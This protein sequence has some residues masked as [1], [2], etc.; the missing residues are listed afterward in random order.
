MQLVQFFARRADTGAGLPSATVYVYVPGS[1]TV[2]ATLYDS[3][4]AIAS[5]PTTAAPY[6]LVTFYARYGEYDIK[7]VLDGY[8]LPT[9]RLPVYDISSP[10]AIAVESFGATNVGVDCTAAFQKA[11]R[12]RTH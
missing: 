4:G 7:G 5:N 6:G 11:L 10:P 12:V 3:A 9:Y 8:T 1:T 2:L